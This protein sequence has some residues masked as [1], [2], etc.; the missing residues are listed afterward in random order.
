[1]FN[2]IASYEFE[3][4]FL[5]GLFVNISFFLLSVGLYWLA[6]LFFTS[7]DLQIKK[8][9]ICHKD[10]AL[11]LVV[12]LCNSLLFKLGFYLW[13]NS[14]IQISDQGS[15]FTCIVDL[16][17]LLLAMDFLMYITHRLAHVEPFYKL[18]HKTHH[19]HHSVN[20]LSLFVLHPLEAIGF[21]LLI[22]LVLMS[23]SVQEYAL[24]AY[25]IINVIWGTIG[26][27]NKAMLD[28]KWIA[29]SDF[30][31]LHHLK[32]QANYGFY[33]TFWDKLAKTY[34]TK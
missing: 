31:N 30:H 26:H 5:I 3:Q 23:F 32:Q 7:K 20:M 17:L 25:G 24:I 27:L 29:L 8:Q 18:V 9:K 16:V 33:T 19:S 10:I 22:I 12:I 6:E 15:I 2:R 1:M 14:W 4:I 11:V 34:L 28:S 21:G 13:Q